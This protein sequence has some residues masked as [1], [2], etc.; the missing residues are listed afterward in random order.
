[1]S[2]STEHLPLNETGDHATG[3][4]SKAILTNPYDVDILL[5]DPT[6]SGLSLRHQDGTLSGLAWAHRELTVCF[7][8]F[9]SSRR[10]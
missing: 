3:K 4:S 9:L 6:L 2:R 10:Y 7:M 8:P 5:T 1:M